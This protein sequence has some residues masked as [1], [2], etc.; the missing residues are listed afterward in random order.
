MTAYIALHAHT[1]G[2]RNQHINLVL[3]GQQGTGKL[4]V[5]KLLA[6]YILAARLLTSSSPASHATAAAG[7]GA[8]GDVQE[9]G[10]QGAQGHGQQGGVS[11]ALLEH[12][13]SLQAAGSLSSSSAVSGSVS[14]VTSSSITSSS[15]RRE[16]VTS[17][18]N[19]S[20]MGVEESALGG[21]AGSQDTSSI[22]CVANVFLIC[23]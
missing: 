19:S 15:E 8:G 1:L 20:A 14:S 7:A 16:S 2:F 5:A 9:H 6:R 18:S 11:S 23:C 17:S 10:G 12:G 4:H 3:L 13:A 22:L 21:A